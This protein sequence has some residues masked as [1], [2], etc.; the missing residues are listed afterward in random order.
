MDIVK[1]IHEA[2]A[3]LSISGF[4]VRGRWMLTASSYLQR[5]WV[6][7][8]PHIIDSMLLGSA[9]LLSIRLQQYPF[10]NNWLTA[11]LLALLLYITLGMVALRFGKTIQVRATAFILAI[12]AFA[13]IAGV[14]FTHDVWLGWL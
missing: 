6:K 8:V 7:L 3:L 12:M 14:A 10:V 1:T 13:Y 9:I 4:V 11:K 2:T 5:K